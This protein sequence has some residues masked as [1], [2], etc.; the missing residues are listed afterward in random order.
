MGT[1]VSFD[2]PYY[3]YEKV[4]TGYNTMRG[5][6]RI[7]MKLL[8]YL[9]DLPDKRGYTPTDDNR[10]PRVRLIKYLWYDEGNPLSMPLPTAKEKLSLLYD[11]TAPV[12][13]TDEMKAA[14]PK[15]YRLYWQKLWLQSQVK[16]QTLMKCYISRITHADEF[17]A[18]VGLAWEIWCNTALQNNT[19]TD[20]YERAYNIEQCL[21]EALHG[22]NIAG[23]GVVD[24][25]RY[26]NLEN[27]SREIYDETGTNVGRRLHMSVTWA[28][29]D[30]DVF[31]ADVPAPDPEDM[32]IATD[33]GVQE[34]LDRIFGRG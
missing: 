2:S 30:G 8:Q 22:V 33:Q 32:D 28:E 9:L 10:M 14:H 1:A 5:S 4:Q 18:S 21:T 23:I 31:A 12:I 16:A 27:G 20:A 13:D 17:H 6:E 26:T 11:G 15:G 24:C 34:T 7:P 25:G 19:R 3:P 29:S